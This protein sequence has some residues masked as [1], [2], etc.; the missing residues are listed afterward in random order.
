MIGTF[1]ILFYAF[2]FVISQ[3]CYALYIIWKNRKKWRKKEKKYFTII[4]PLF[5]KE[6]PSTFHMVRVKCLWIFHKFPDIHSLVFFSFLC[7]NMLR[8]AVH[9]YAGELCCYKENLDWRSH[10]RLQRFTFHLYISALTQS[11]KVWWSYNVANMK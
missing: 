2:F 4:T 5:T 8:Y 3:S 1:F 11:V 10:K 6:N 9:V 7:D